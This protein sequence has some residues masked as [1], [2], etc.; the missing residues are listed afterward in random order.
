VELPGG[1]SS[2]FAGPEAGITFCGRLQETPA[3]ERMPTRLE[4]R[5]TA[6]ASG[7]EALRQVETGGIVPDLLLTDTA[8]SGLSGV[9]L[10]RRLRAARPGLKVA[11]M[12]GYADPDPAPEP[13][14]R[15]HRVS[16]EADHH[17]RPDRVHSTGD[18]ARIAF[19]ARS[20]HDSR[21]SP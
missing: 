10:I 3:L 18:G 1:G 20:R 11:R 17:R 7:D 15:S 21:R 9:A 12:S 13:R 19:G 14:T 16:P 2:W 6:A 8:L 4:C 5:L